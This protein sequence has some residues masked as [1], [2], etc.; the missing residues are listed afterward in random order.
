MFLQ[1]LRSSCQEQDPELAKKI[2]AN[3]NIELGPED[4]AEFINTDHRPDSLLARI[5]PDNA[6]EVYGQYGKDVKRKADVERLV[7]FVAGVAEEMVK[8]GEK[9]AEF[10]DNLDYPDMCRN[11]KCCGPE[12]QGP[13]NRNV[14]GQT[15]AWGLLDGAGVNWVF[16]GNV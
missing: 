16:E 15:S 2:L 3:H 7:P 8:T 6:W 14:F 10:N 1:C 9:W 12:C 11:G 5:A 13:M 4:L